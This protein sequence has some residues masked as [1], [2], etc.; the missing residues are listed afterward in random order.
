[1]Y[2]EQGMEVQIVIDPVSVINRMNP[3]QS[4]EQFLNRGSE[5]IRMRVAEMIKN[6]TN[7]DEAYDLIIDWLK[8]VHYNWGELVD[9]DNCHDKKS[10]VLECVDDHIYLQINPA[11]KGIDDKMILNLAKK[12]NIG[13]SRLTYKVPDENGNLKTATT[14]RPVMVGAEYFY[15]LYKMPH[16][17]A[18][19]IGYVNQNRTPIRSSSATKALY[20]F[21]QTPIRLGEDEIRNLVAASGA[22]VAARLLGTYANSQIAVDKLASHLLFDE[23]PSELRRVEIPIEEIINTNSIVGVT[24]HIFSCMGIDI[25]PTPEQLSD[26]LAAQDTFK[27]KAVDDGEEMVEEDE[28]SEDDGNDQ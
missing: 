2:D 10:F 22:E 9:K 8:D 3:S 26:L 6:D 27:G 14:R 16:V 11:Q 24:K 19:G 28:G 20:P 12:W 7:Y 25:N 17:R 21:S 5:L 18:A 4:I 1:M 15:L 13:K 23:R